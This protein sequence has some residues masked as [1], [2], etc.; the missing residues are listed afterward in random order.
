MS[1]LT[2]TD[3]R[4]N[5]YRLIDQACESHESILVTDKRNSAVLVAEEA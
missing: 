1:V 3:A 4:S 5:L 2:A